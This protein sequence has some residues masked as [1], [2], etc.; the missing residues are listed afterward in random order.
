MA[1]WMLPFAKTIDAAKKYVVSD[2][3]ERVDWNAELIRGPQ[4]GATIRQ[5]KEQPG[6]GLLVGGVRLPT[7]LAAMGLIDDYEFIVHPRIA[8]H[9]PA[10][11]GG[12]PK[13]LDL[14]LVDR[15]E[16]GSGAVAMRFRPKD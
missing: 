12:L 9:G 14:Q 6:R 7:A 4:L 16:Y 13:V 3:L 5:L 1:D 8:G 2:S 10:L 11:L 15:L